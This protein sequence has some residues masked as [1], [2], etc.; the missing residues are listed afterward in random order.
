VVP[1]GSEGVDGSADAVFPDALPATGMHLGINVLFL[2][3]V[4]II[5]ASLMMLG[6]SRNRNSRGK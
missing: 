5:G 1:N 3:L 2:A 4:L 6:G